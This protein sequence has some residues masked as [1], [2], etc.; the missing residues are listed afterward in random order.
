MK[1][2]LG[3]T[4]SAIILAQHGSIVYT[5]AVAM[6]QKR[7]SLPF[8]FREAF[9]EET[10]ASGGYKGCLRSRLQVASKGTPMNPIKIASGQFCDPHLNIR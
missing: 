9:P 3:V 4:L 7:L 8:G 10:V 2:K 5:I 1:Q 6:S